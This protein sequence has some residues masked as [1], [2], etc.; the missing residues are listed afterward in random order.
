MIMINIIKIIYYII[1]VCVIKV[2]RF[3]I[4]RRNRILTTELDLLKKKLAE[5]EREKND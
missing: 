4:N 5:D 2:R 3:F 1:L